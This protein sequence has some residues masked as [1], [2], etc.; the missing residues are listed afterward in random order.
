MQT[1][2]DSKA[3]SPLRQIIVLSTEI[4]RPANLDRA[5]ICNVSIVHGRP[6]LLSKCLGGEK[7]REGSRSDSQSG[8]SAVTIRQIVYREQSDVSIYILDSAILLPTFTYTRC[9]I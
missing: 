2:I 8:R 7:A 9:T 5:S 3:T 4:I 1:P 6:L